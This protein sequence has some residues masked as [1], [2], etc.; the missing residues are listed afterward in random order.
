MSNPVLVEVTRGALVESRHRG[1][2]A[3]A[4]PKAA[5][6]LAVGD[7]A[8]PVFPRSA[9]KALQAIALVEQGAA[10]RYGFDDE[11]LALACASHSGE[12]AHVAGV[13]RMLA[14]TGLDAAALRCGVHW[15]I[16][17]PAAYALARTGHRLRATQQLLR[18]ACR[19]PLPR[20][21]NGR[22]YGRLFPAR[23]PGAAASA[24]RAGRFY[25]HRARAGRLR[26]RRLLGADLGGAAAKS[27]SWS[28]PNS[29]RVA[30]CRR[31][32]PLRRRGC[33]RHAPRNP[34]S[35]PAPSGSAP[36]SCSS[37]A[38]AFL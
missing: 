20:L 34:G 18:Q 35:S 14:K 38:A 12:P 29:A 31:H 33:D 30:V 37:S 32:A 23:T 10:D 36:R 17:Q 4:M 11:E 1:A 28:S 3:V 26:H 25:R 22:R 24:R 15:P 27:R 8:A 13:A 7:I 6:C 9:I 21:R 2:V 5:S 19:L 16:S